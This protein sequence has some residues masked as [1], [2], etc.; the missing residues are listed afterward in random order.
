[1]TTRPQLKALSDRLGILPLYVNYNA[2]R[3]YLT[4][5]ETNEAILRAMG[6]GDLDEG[7][8]YRALKTLETR[9]GSRLI[10]PVRV[11]ALGPGTEHL[12]QLRTHAPTGAQ[13]DWSLT[14]T[15]EIETAHSFEGRSVASGDGGV[16]EVALPR[17]LETGYH[18]ID[19]TAKVAGGELHGRQC[20]I[21]TPDRCTGVSDLSAQKQLSGIWINLYSLRSRRNWGVGD[22][23]DLRVLVAWSAEVG[24]DFVGLNP[25]H[26]LR[27]RG[28]D[29]SPYRPVSRL[30]RNE[31]YLDIGAI[32]EQ[33]GCVAARQLMD[34]PRFRAER[35]RL[36]NA[37]WIDYDA[38]FSLKRSVLECLHAEF[39]ARH[40][41][42]DTPRGREFRDYLDREGAALLDFA[43]FTALDEYFRSATPAIRDWHDWPA[44]FRDARSAEVDRFRSEHGKEIAFQCFVQFELDRQLAA[45]ADLARDK[46]LSIGLYQDLAIGT[47]P[48]G[49]DPWMFRELFIDGLSIGAPPDELTPLGQNWGLPPMN[50]H[51]LRDSAYEYWRQLL[52]GAFAHSG[53]LRIDH[54]MGL[55]RQFWIPDG[56]DGGG[57]AYVRLPADELF[58]ILALE[59][60]RNRAVVI[61]EDLGT[62]PEGFSELLERWGV[63]STRVLY[64][65]REQE[66]EFIPPQNHSNRAY[67]VV[68]THDMVPLAG[69]REGRDLLLRRK[70]GAIADD[71]ALEEAVAQRRR[72]FE[73]LLRRL[74]SEGLV[75]QVTDLDSDSSR[76]CEAT[77]AF[78]RRTPAPLIGISLD[79]LA[80][81][82]EPVN[83]PGVGQDQYAN[84]TRRMAVSLEDLRASEA[85]RKAVGSAT[86]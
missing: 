22:F 6:F 63:L 47:S 61:G 27:N 72:D 55:L 50:P 86:R 64:F 45:I 49:A 12:V 5:D 10:E 26:A 56:C 77:I 83:L 41:S 33:S 71:A 29:V 53:A 15:P 13:V 76:L 37:D 36:R 57:G 32:E 73:A 11:C 2:T 20:L 51:R 60:H 66:G 30:Y 80:G 52:R 16:V 28:T 8:V 46:G 74:Q 79:D 44:Q 24:L 59:S 3:Q 38:V 23:G 40:A 31:L 34:S 48:Y 75:A 78:L 68:A 39:E 21:V 81:E 54:A 62:V 58:A 18:R 43:T 42:G 7:S 9:A 67:S 65:E 84:W 82:T 19:A 70:A 1:M 35:D 25:L 17:A 14:L 69:F 85:I 4:S